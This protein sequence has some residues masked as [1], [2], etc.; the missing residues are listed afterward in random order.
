M[1]PI[2]PKKKKNNSL[3]STFQFPNSCSM[4]AQM[5]NMADDSFLEGE[6]FPLNFS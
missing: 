5:S 4:E 6:A 2:R 3:I 1:I